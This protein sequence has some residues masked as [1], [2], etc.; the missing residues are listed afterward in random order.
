[1]TL[2]GWRRLDL[3]LA[4]GL[5]LTAFAGYFWASTRLPSA[6]VEPA[7]RDFWFD[8]DGPRV[9][10][11]LTGTTA[12]AA[13]PRRT[14]RD[15]PPRWAQRENGRH[16][17]YPLAAAPPVRLLMLA[18]VPPLTAA[19]L[20]STALGG[21]WVAALFALLR[22]IGIRPWDAFLFSLIGG[23]S[24]AAVFWHS[25]PETFSLG[26]LTVML[27]VG[28]AARSHVRKIGILPLAIAGV[29]TLGITVTNWTAG[30]AAAFMT[31]PFRR[32]IG[33]TAAALALVL[34]LLYGVERRFFPDVE[35]VRQ[36]NTRGGLLK[37]ASG[38]PLV[39]ARSF[40]FHS[41][42]L[43]RPD[44]RSTERSLWLFTQHSAIGSGSAAAWPATV[45]WIGLLGL[46]AFAWRSLRNTVARQVLALTLGAQL[47]V[48]LV[49]GIETFLFSLH[50]VPV[51]LAIA[52]LGTLTPQRRVALG[53]AGV[54]LIAGGL[55]N[56]LLF[57]DSARKAR[58]HFGAG[59]GST[60]R[61]VLSDRF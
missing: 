13:D 57:E 56:L 40:F 49:F 26:S 15:R 9:Y 41:L 4:L 35:F 53:L 59:M 39:V 38:G 6:L 33:V 50:W 52:A 47:A 60:T 42:V 48:H 28:L 18:G 34:V 25:S 7:G 3:L 37:K 2:N 5:F 16:P 23:V 36:D 20:L 46:G 19:L 22:V 8:S 61:F 32:A 1:M 24:S 55:N 45:A 14:W 51:L 29:A 54:L 31:L 44:Y 11:T 30:I 17:L 10:A 21:L 12:V 27:A 58:E 43:P